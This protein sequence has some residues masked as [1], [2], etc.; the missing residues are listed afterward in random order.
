MILRVVLTFAFEST[1]I[2]YLNTGKKATADSSI[3]RTGK[4]QIYSN[5]L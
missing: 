4:W 2:V 1:Q 5:I 3:C